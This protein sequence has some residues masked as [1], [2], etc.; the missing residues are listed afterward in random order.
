MTETGRRVDNN[1]CKPVSVWRRI[2]APADEIFGVLVDPQQHTELDGSGMLRGSVSSRLV[3]GVGDFFVMKMYY[4]RHGDYEMINHVVEYERNR[5]IAWEPERSGVG[6]ARWGHRWT[7]DL[8]PDGP[9]ATIVTE[10]YD[11][12]PAPEQERLN[13]ENGKVWLDSMARTL[14][15]LDDLCTGRSSQPG[16]GPSDGHG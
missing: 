15:R 14:D 4:S 3:S 10:I 1:E 7:F 13:M 9:D 11:C 6:H 2:E 16:D 5:R 8:L 12:G